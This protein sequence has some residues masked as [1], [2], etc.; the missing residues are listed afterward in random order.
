MAYFIFLKYLDSLEEFKKNP[1]VKIPPKSPCANFQSPGIFKNPIFI[2]KGILFRFRPSLARA[3][4][5]CPAGHHVHAQA[6]QPKQPWRNCLKVYFLRHCTFRQ[7]RLL[8]LT[9]LPCGPRPSASSPSPR[10]PIS[11]T[12][13]PLLI[14]SGH[15]AP[16]G[17]QHQDANRTLCSPTL[18][19]HF[20]PPLTPQ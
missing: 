19:P 18:I 10:W 3:S 16:P 4:P 2:Q 15:P 7:R 11:V 17:L 9:S 13:P 6:I 14:A 1:H 8:S 5:L 12:S 20:N